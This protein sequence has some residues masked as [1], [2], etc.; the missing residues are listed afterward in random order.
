MILEE[1]GLGSEVKIEVSEELVNLPDYKQP[2]TTRIDFDGLLQPALLL[3]EDLSKGCGGQTWPAGMVLA[4]FLLREP[5]LTSLHGKNMSVCYCV[6][7]DRRRTSLRGFW[8]ADLN[9][10]LEVAW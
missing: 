2:N 5:Q 9:L 10:A 8:A 1:D 7:G 6:S 3:H 4:K